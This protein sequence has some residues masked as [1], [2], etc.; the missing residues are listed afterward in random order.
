METKNV[1]CFEFE[2]EDRVYRLQMPLGAPLGEAYEAVSSFQ[3]ELVRLINE[4]AER[5]KPK[6]PEEAPE[7][8]V[9]PEVIES[10]EE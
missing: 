8:A 1:I 9:E 10:K 3:M 2:K 5:S 4:H 7:E 6:E